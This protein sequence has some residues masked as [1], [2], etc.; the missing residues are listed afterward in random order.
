MYCERSSSSMRRVTSATFSALLTW[1]H[2]AS[3]LARDLVDRLAD[4][5]VERGDLDS[6]EVDRRAR[7]AQYRSSVS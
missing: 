2:L 4:A 1:K 5:E 3:R 6:D 7:G